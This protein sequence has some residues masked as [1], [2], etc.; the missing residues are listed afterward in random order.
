MTDGVPITKSGKKLDLKFLEKL[1]TRKGDVEI[2]IS[3]RSRNVSA[4]LT[5]CTFRAESCSLF[6]HQFNLL[7]AAVKY[8]ALN[9]WRSQRNENLSM[10]FSLVGTFLARTE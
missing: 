6:E 9:S 5:L 4:L 10:Q 8:K 7:M 3:E 1:A 2:L